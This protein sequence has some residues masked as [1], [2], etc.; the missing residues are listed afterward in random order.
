MPIYYSGFA[1]SSF[2]SG[3]VQYLFYFVSS[4]PNYSRTGIKMYYL[5]NSMLLLF[6]SFPCLL[7]VK[8]RFYRNIWG[9]NSPVGAVCREVNN[10]ADSTIVDNFSITIMATEYLE[11]WKSEKHLLE[12]L[13]LPFPLEMRKKPKLTSRWCGSFERTR[14]PLVT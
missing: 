8:K 9:Y 2:E 13:S 11:D 10:F 12:T 4:N 14:A 1:H 6:C 5:F 3:F 7:F